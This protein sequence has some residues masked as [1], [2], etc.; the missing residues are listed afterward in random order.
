MGRAN[1]RSIVFEAQGLAGTSSVEVIGPLQHRQRFELA[2]QDAATQPSQ[3]ASPPWHHRLF[4][5]PMPMPMPM[6]LLA[7]VHP[8]CPRG[9]LV[10]G[11]LSDRLAAAPFDQ[12]VEVAFEV[13]YTATV[14]L[15]QPRDRGLC[16][17]VIPSPGAL[18]HERITTPILL[19]ST[20]PH[21]QFRPRHQ[22]TRIILAAHP[23]GTW[24]AL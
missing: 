22:G 17:P 16:Q 21:P 13:C 5:L 20:I 23:R 9:V 6:P 2:V 18:R 1:L 8:P 12:G 15:R 19:E 3:P 11:L 4:G 24:T 10:S 7:L 14:R